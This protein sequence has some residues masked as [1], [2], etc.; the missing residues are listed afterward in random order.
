[1]TEYCLRCKSPLVGRPVMW[2]KDDIPEACVELCEPC[3]KSKQDAQYYEGW[4]RSNIS[5]RR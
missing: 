2:I 5:F 4:Q 1:M 3:Y